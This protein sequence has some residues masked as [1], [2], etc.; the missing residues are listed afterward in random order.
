MGITVFLRRSVVALLSVFHSQIGTVARRIVSSFLA[1]GLFVTVV[2]TAQAADTVTVLH[3]NDFHGRIFPY[4]DKAVNPDKPVGGAA[5]LAEMIKAERAKNPGGV[6]L[7]S[8]GDMFQGT[9]VSNLYNGRPVLDF[10]NMVGFDAMVLG[11]HEFDWGR[12]VLGGFIGA[13]RFPVI[14]ANITD[15]AGRFMPGVRPYVIV[16]RR[17]CKFAIIGLTTPDVVYMANGKYLKDLTFS[18]PEG[19]LPGIINEVK[20]KGAHIVILLTHLGFDADKR[21]A[22]SIDGIDL[23]IGG[24]S[25]TAVT[26]AVR[27]GRTLIAQAGYN[28][29]YLG[30]V[31]LKT[32]KDEQTGRV[33]LLE[34]RGR[35]KVV[36][37]GPDAPFDA[38]IAFMADGY[39]EK[40]KARFQ[41]VVGESA[42]DLTR[43]E[44]GESSMGGVITD[45]MREA[46]GAEVA[47]QNTGGI[48]ADIPKGKITMEDVYTVLPFDNLLVTM[49]MKGKDLLE[50]FETGT[51][52]GRG[53]LQVSG[54][55]IVFNLKNPEGKRVVRAD[56]GGTPV[57]P[58]RTYRVVTN[59][60]LAAGGDRFPAFAKGTNVSQG[61]ELRDA[62]LRYLKSHSPLNSP[63]GGRITVEGP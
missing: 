60:F 53:I 61:E 7:L 27:V 20:K 47:F 37:A 45:A 63:T 57:D 5:Y 43:R 11:N 29:L 46:A 13:G 55:R 40:I 26:E 3:V 1:V 32:R 31:D 35:L 48:R 6:I 15:T 14:A 42:V 28:G 8:A 22:A 16:E 24:H 50:L 39:G 4:I 58:S 33:A 10:M 19:V 44:S 49:D 17:G 41:E 52:T 23:I 38:A 62:F 2:F 25:H 21:L 30:V 9:P 56:V 12:D 36:S 59:D 51:G 54:V 34:G 18:R